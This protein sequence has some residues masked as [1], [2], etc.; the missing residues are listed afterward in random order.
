MENAPFRSG[1]STLPDHALTQVDAAARIILAQASK[2]DSSQTSIL[3]GCRAQ[4]AQ[5][6]QLADKLRGRKRCAAMQ[7][8]G[9][10]ATAHRRPHDCD[11]HVAAHGRCS[12]GEALGGQA[13]GRVA[14]EHVEMS[15]TRQKYYKVVLLSSS[16]G[17]RCTHMCVL[18]VSFESSARDRPNTPRD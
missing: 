9:A 11:A 13:A 15:E 17:M 14:A 16:H 3:E 4:H 7:R 10:S 12:A 18:K 1:F 6:L 5:W 8:R 2:G